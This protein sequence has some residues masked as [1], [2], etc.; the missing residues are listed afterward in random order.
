MLHKLGAILAA[1]AALWTL[2]VSGTAVYIDTQSGI[3]TA[4]YGM[5]EVALALVALIIAVVTFFAHNLYA[6]LAL[7]AIGVIGMLFTSKAVILFMAAVAVGG[8]IAVMGRRRASKLGTE[9]P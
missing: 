4:G 8:L 1:L 2:Y 6:G 5:L 7:V 9:R 3:E